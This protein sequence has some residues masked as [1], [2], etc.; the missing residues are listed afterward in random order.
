MNS[1]NCRKF[2]LSKHLLILSI[3]GHY[4]SWAFLKQQSARH[5]RNDVVNKAFPSRGTRTMESMES[6]GSM[7]SVQK[8]SRPPRG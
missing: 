2:Q 5:P 3:T 6:M 8:A 4:S 1:I 7:G